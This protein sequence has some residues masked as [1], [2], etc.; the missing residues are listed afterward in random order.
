MLS[1]TGQRIERPSPRRRREALE[2]LL[3][4]RAGHVDR[5][6]SY[7][8][9]TGLSF[10]GLWCLFEREEVRASVL[11]AP[12]PGRTATLLVTSPRREA[13]IPVVAALVDHAAR[14]AGELGVALVQALVEPDR[15]LERA[16][17][18]CGGLRRIARLRSPARPRPRRGE[19]EVPPLPP[20]LAPE[21]WREE[22]V[23]ETIAALERSYVDT[24][25]C[26]G[27]T[28]LRRGEDILAGHRGSGRFDPA[29]WTVVRATS[30]ARAGRLVATCLMNPQP[31][32]GSVELVY[33]GIDPDFR[34]KG[35][36]TALLARGLDAASRRAERRVTLAVD[37]ANEP[38][39]SLYARFGFRGD[40]ARD[41]FVRAVP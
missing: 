8:D 36:G 14:H 29:M 32:T 37:D 9:A 11:A 41:A 23:P 28:G 19:I 34:G 16:V 12:S 24:L 39:L 3:G 33:L 21:T 35:L 5:F 20:G 30:G 1:P 13:E 38:A 27:L 4:G 2:V 10:D 26:P 6:L 15:P 22:L 40:V 7:A 25:D 31:A 18:E 17:F